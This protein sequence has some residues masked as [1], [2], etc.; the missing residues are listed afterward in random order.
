MVLWIARD[1]DGGLYTFINKPWLQSVLKIW[2]DFPIYI[3]WKDECSYYKQ[4]DA[5]LYPEITFENSPQ[6]IEIKLIN[7]E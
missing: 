2:L 5:K 6:M 3:D 4:L 7:K 1:K